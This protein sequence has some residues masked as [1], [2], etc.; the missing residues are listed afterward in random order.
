MA[1]VQ[2]QT[3]PGSLE[4]TRPQI[5]PDPARRATPQVIA[6]AAPPHSQSGIGQSFI[7]S[8][9]VI[10]GATVF[11]PGEL[12]QIFEPYLA[13]TVRQSELEKIAQSITARYRKAGYLLSYAVVPAQSV[14]S[15]IA[16]IRV[17]EGY[18]GRV[19]L[20]SDVRTAT[21]V[22]DIF[23]SLAAE[24]P[25]HRD[26]LERAIGLGRDVPG[27]IISDVQISRSPEDPALHVLT[28]VMAKDRIRGLA[29]I[30]N[31]GTAPDA[32]MRGYSSFSISSLLVPGDQLQAD[33]FVIPYAKFRYAFGQV[34]GS[35]P[36]GS[37]GLRLSA[38][39][40][41]G[42]QFER[43]AGPNQ[44]GVARQLVG[45]LSYPFVKSRALSVAGTLQ[46]GALKSELEQLG[47]V[48]QRDRLQ[49]ARAWLD[50]IRLAGTRID[51]RI[52]VSQG[53]DL[54][55]ATDRGDPLASRL[56]ASANFTKFNASVQVTAPLSDRVR[57][58]FDSIAQYSTRPLLAPEEFALGGSRIGRA[59]DFNENT[60]DHGIGAMIEL[61]YRLDGTKRFVDNIEVF[62]FADG[63]GAFRDRPSLGLAKE[64]WLASV[65]AGARFSAFG[66]LW[67]PEIGLPVALSDGDRG[68]RAYF[69]TTKVF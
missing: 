68:V 31:R 54:G 18:V 12:A 4:R 9:V 69:S 2:A 10:D 32:R 27:V 28:V 42:D 22:R 7:L 66:I 47:T 40:S 57:V 41:S 67:S 30:D 55:P 13:T 63:G 59:F 53:L 49:V 56:F 8:A 3:D 34:K 24:R 5:D 14:Q 17:V 6:P 51:A 52:G 35:V 16:H 21:A 44:N 25:L 61:V 58:R 37:N 20:A 65:G 23:E 50:L 64:K 45:D 62:A 11:D 48:V 1:T 19:R 38:A 46:F 60:G 36:I 15:G 29:Y 43:L 39:A 26:R 33:L